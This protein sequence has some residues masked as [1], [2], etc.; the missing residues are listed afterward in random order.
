MARADGT[1]LIDT[2]LDS[3][4]LEAG[5]KGIGRSAGG[6]ALKSG[7][8]IGTA[9]G[10]AIL[11]ATGY[12]VSKG[13]SRALNIEDAKAALKGLGYAAEEVERVTTNVLDA[14]RGTAFSLDEGMTIAASALA[15]GVQ[16]GKELTSYIRLVGDAAT[17]AKRPINDMGNIF[18]KVMATG[19]LQGDE[20]NQMMEAGI[21]IL[22]WLAEEYGTT[23]QDLRKMVSKGEVDSAVFLRAMENNI[24][25]AALASGETVRGAMKNV[26]AAVGRAGAAL[27]TGLLGPTKT[28]LDGLIADIDGLSGYFA[29]AGRGLSLLIADPTAEMTARQKVMFG[30]VQNG[31]EILSAALSDIFTDIGTGIITAI[32]TAADV[33]LQVIN[34][35]AASLPTLLPIIVTGLSEI[36]SQIAA[37][38]PSFLGSLLDGFVALFVSLAEQLPV[39]VPELIAGVIG[40]VNTIADKLPTL[41]PVLLD[42]AVQMLLALVQAVPV[43]LPSV[44]EAIVGL[45]NALVGMLPTLIPQLMGGMVTLL[46]AIIDAML[47][48]QPLID[49][50]MED[51]IAALVTAIIDNY[52]VFLQ[53]S[54]TLFGAIVQGLLK[55]LPTLIGNIG[56]T[57]LVV[58]KALGKGLSA[59][60]LLEIGKDMVRGLWEG[61]KSVKDWLLEK[62]SGFVGD[63]T[64]GIKNFFGIKSP[65][66][67][68]ETEIGVNLALGIGKGF[69]KE[70]G[71]VMGSMNRSLNVNMARI[72]VPEPAAAPTTINFNGRVQSYSETIRAMRDIESGLVF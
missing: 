60:K 38:L 71:D 6:F 68:F 72:A 44:I 17:I 14:V 48:S 7:A 27:V 47:V 24:G 37:A 31:A 23:A 9:I 4:G 67:L 52:P 62:I 43:I 18:N 21:P 54:F 50:A 39:L 51:I 13:I 59:S 55:M 8:V 12:I 10:G 30:E 65:S 57:A 63:V 11:T 15:S 64:Q 5:L 3:K 2:K 66:K 1:I 42:A 35:I 36:I 69:D 34:S 20:M 33:L 19:V 25:G 49:Q 56:R 22:Q 32:P 41:V 53:A 29:E 45:V 70:V 58:L 61:I 26:E 40:L 16:Q 28:A 46:N